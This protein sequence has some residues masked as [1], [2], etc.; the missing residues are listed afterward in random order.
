MPVSHAAIPIGLAK[1]K[2]STLKR[3]EPG[4]KEDAPPNKGSRLVFAGDHLQL[5]PILKGQYLSSE[6]LD[7][8]FGS[9]MT[10]LMRGAMEKDLVRG[11][12]PKNPRKRERTLGLTSILTENFRMVSFIRCFLSKLEL[13]VFPLA[14]FG[15]GRVCASTVRGRIQDKQFCST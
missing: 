15:T 3:G 8:V 2:G 5:P 1:K 6:N 9:I 4:Y 10:C 12:R 13:I 7:P 14:G 11:L